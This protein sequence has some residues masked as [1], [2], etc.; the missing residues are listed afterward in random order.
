M[1]QYKT[2]VPIDIKSLFYIPS[3]HFENFGMGRMDPG[4]SLY[5]RKVRGSA[6]RVLLEIAKMSYGG[7]V[8]IAE[9]VI[10]I[11]SSQPN[12]RVWMAATG[13]HPEQDEESASRV[14]AVRQRR[15]R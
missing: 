4:V 12:A 7:H 14:A 5:C 15:G 9:I 13:P 11:A 3:Q 1:L 10:Q 2:D 6:T 8:Y